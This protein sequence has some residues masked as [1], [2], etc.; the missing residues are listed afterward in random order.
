MLKPRGGPTTVTLRGEPWPPT[1]F[2][3]DL[4]AGLS[5]V[6]IPPSTSSSRSTTDLMSLTRSPFV[7]TSPPSSGPGA[8]T[9]RLFLP[10]QPGVGLSPDQ[11]Y[12]LSLPVPLQVDLLRFTSTPGPGKAMKNSRAT[13]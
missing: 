12:L 4:P 3:K 7:I 2:V 13:R 5:L 8:G 11:G 10:G 6:S 9:L 1:S